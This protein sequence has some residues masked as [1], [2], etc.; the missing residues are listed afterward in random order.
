MNDKHHEA[1]GAAAISSTL[2]PVK[3]IRITS[4]RLHLSAVGGAAENFTVIIN[5]ATAPAY[6][7][8]LFSQDMTAVQDILWIPERPIPIVNND[9]IDFAYTN[10]NTRTYGLEV[11]Y[12]V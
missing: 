8:L 7:V 5:S 6:D 9:L 12:E 11:T 2:T 4:V 1:T 10:T 3:P